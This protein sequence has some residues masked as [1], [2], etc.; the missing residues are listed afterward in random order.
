ML[1]PD[2]FAPM[3]AHFALVVV[4]ALLTGLSRIQARASGATKGLQLTTGQQNWPGR[5]QQ[6]S[7]AFNNQFETPIYF[8]V[9]MLLAM[10]AEFSSAAFVAL[11]WGYVASRVLHALIYV[12]VNIIPIRFLV[13]LAG[14]AFIIAMWVLLALRVFGQ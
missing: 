11:A 7:S 12:T 8:Y 6:F 4:L 14:F 2:L 5:V 3:L 10:M 13:F 9:V 1:N